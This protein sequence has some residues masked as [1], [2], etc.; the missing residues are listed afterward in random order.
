MNRTWERVR[1]SKISAGLIEKISRLL[2]SRGVFYIGTKHPALRDIRRTIKRDIRLMKKTYAQR[3]ET[4]E[5]LGG[6]RKRG[7]LLGY[8]DAF[9]LWQA[10]KQ[11][12][13]VEGDIAEV[14]VY[15]GGSAEVLCMARGKPGAVHLFDT[16]AG[17][18]NVSKEDED[19][20]FHAGQF[21]ASYE[22]VRQR[23]APYAGVHIWRGIFP[24]TAGAVEHTRFSFV[25]LDVDAVKS[26]RDCLAF[27]YPRMT[28]GGIIISH[29]WHILPAKKAYEE[30]FRDKPEP[31]VELS[32]M[33][34]AIVK[35]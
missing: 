18:P 4:M 6:I 2:A 20:D 35:A 21:C 22:D 7:M 23:L 16:F 5:I 10:V 14:G 28:R 33:Q 9:R 26:T 31:I 15:N 34:C 17:L 32:V 19:A 29:D 11:T 3:R 13:K 1:N 8:D 27:F 24:E 30:F 12:E 25:H